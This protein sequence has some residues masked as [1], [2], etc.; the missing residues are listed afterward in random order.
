MRAS[1]A[2]QVLALGAAFLTLGVS[3]AMAQSAQ[4]VRDDANAFAAQLATANQGV[5]D[6]EATVT[7]NVPGYT[8]ATTPQSSYMNDPAALDA[9]KLGA[10]QSNEAYRLTVDGNLVRPQIP[11]ASVDATLARGNAINQDPAA[12]AQGLASGQSGQCV[13]LPPSTTSTGTFEASCNIGVKVDSGPRSCPITLDHQ[14]AATHAYQCTR[15]HEKGRIC[16]QG[17]LNNSTT[18]P[19]PTKSTM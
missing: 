6:N 2:A 3:G 16:L 18:A 13:P 4:S 15:L 8:G 12:I 1:F 7:A 10:A 5:A 9:A 14:F 11:S 19:N 17:S